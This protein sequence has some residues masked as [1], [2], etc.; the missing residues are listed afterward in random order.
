MEE[1][2]LDCQECHSPEFNY[3][4][5]CGH[6][7]CIKCWNQKAGAGEFLEQKLCPQCQTSQIKTMVTRQAGKAVEKIP[8]KRPSIKKWHTNFTG[9]QRGPRYAQWREDAT[10]QA[11]DSFEIWRNLL[12]HPITGIKQAVVS[13]S[14]NLS[15]FSVY[16]YTLMLCFSDMIP[17]VPLSAANARTMSDFFQNF[18]QVPLILFPHYHL[19]LLLM[20]LC[21]FGIGFIIAFKN[22]ALVGCLWFYGTGRLLGGKS[23][24]LDNI[25]MIGYILFLPVIFSLLLAIPIEAYLYN[26]HA[27]P[28]MAV[29]MAKELQSMSPQEAKARAENTAKLNSPTIIQEIAGCVSSWYDINITY[30]KIGIP[31]PV[32]GFVRSSPWLIVHAVISHLLLIWGLVLSFLGLKILN[33][34]STW[35]TVLVFSVPLFIYFMISTAFF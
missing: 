33:G 21:S 4:C 30:K 22:L 6:R 10:L 31:S 13:G 27:F 2:P 23:T 26:H 19:D 28:L 32:E 34:F 16:L 1:T 25:I 29:D 3:R 9:F 24:L 8:D 20:L 35:K 14:L 11:E 7:L 15:I 18:V 5:T 12:F 17:W